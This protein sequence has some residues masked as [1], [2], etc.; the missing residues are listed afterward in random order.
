MIGSQD[1]IVARLK[2]VLPSRW[3]GD[4][5]PILDSLLAGLG[6]GWSWLYG[7]LTFVV[8]QT[9]VA[10]STGLWLDLA[11]QDYFGIR[12]AR[13]GAESDASM[14]TRILREIRRE[15]GTRSAIV[16][17]LQDLTGRAPVVFEPAHP[18]D[19]GAWGTALG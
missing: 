3:F 4:D 7:L 15:R 8:A 1:D 14:R 2:A 9:R 12:L 19:T 10:S 16:A 6:A 5:T 11:A 18:A 13:R 17:A